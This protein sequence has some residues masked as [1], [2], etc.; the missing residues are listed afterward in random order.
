MFSNIRATDHLLT[1][2]VQFSRGFLLGARND[3][4]SVLGV[5][6]CVL[7]FA[8][9]FVTFIRAQSVEKGLHLDMRDSPKILSISER[10]Y[11][12]VIIYLLAP[13]FMRDTCYENYIQ[14]L[15]QFDFVAAQGE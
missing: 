8:R 15:T 9:G 6:G 4:E 11:L 12:H 13:G 14:I 10:A 7:D 2:E 3:F 5:L 1:T